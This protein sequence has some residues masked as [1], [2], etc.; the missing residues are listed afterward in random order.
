MGLS[1]VSFAAGFG[2]RRIHE[3]KQ[4]DEL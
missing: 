1:A 4:Q 2:S 3:K